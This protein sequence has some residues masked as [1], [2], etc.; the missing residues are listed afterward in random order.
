MII[1]AIRSSASKMR[2][3]A[4]NLP[5]LPTSAVAHSI[6]TWGGGGRDRCEAPN[7]LGMPSVDQQASVAGLRAIPAR[8][9]RVQ[10]S[11]LA[12]GTTNLSSALH[13]GEIRTSQKVFHLE[14]YS[15]LFEEQIRSIVIHHTIK[16]PQESFLNR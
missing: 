8:N 10:G 11:L 14:M 16:P 13:Q 15:L 3:M 7:Q 2:T 4:Y 6:A 9:L 5:P 12:L 1:V